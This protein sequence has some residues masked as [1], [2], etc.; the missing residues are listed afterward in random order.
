VLEDKENTIHQA[1]VKGTWRGAR[2][3]AGK[4]VVL[5]R[6]GQVAGTEKLGHAALAEGLD[7]HNLGDLAVGQAHLHKLG[8]ARLGHHDDAAKSADGK[9]SAKER[10]AHLL[11]STRSI[12]SCQELEREESI[13]RRSQRIII[14]RAHVTSTQCKNKY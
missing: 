8:G 5:D 3:T 14:S 7:R 1:I 9:G 2:S 11:K 13:N 6:D 10:E 4:A 12:I